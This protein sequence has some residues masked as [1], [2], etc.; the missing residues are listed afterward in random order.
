MKKRPL[1][2]AAGGAAGLLLLLCACFWFIAGTQSFMTGMGRLAAEKGSELLGTRVEVGEVCVDSPWTVTVRDVALYD[3]RDELLARAD[4]ATVRISLFGMIA[5]KPA[6][7]VEDVLVRRPEAWIV[8]RGDGS[9]NFRDLM[10]EESEPSG[11]R[12]VVR[13]EFGAAALAMDGKSLRVSDV[14]GS[15]DFADAEAMGVALKA[16]SD[17]A[18][19]SLSGKVG[20]ENASLEI[21]GA[22]IDLAPYLPWLPKDL[23]PESVTI[24]GG[25]VKSLAATVEKQ[26]EDLSCRGTAEFAKGEVRV[27]DTEIRDIEGTAEFTERNVK[28]AATA[29]AEGQRAEVRGS[30]G[31]SGE[32]PTL[33]LIARSESFDPGEV[34]KDIPY[35]GAVA[36][37][38]RVTGTPSSPAVDGE[39]FAKE[40]AVADYGFMN[41]RARAAYADGRIT[42]HSLTAEMF[43]GRVEG[44]GEFDAPT[45]A[46]DGR[47]KAEDV[48]ASNFE[49]LAE[50]LAGRVSAD[51]GF[52]GNANALEDVSV[53]GSVWGRDM[54]CYDIS[55]PEFSASFYHAPEKTVIDYLSVHL[56]ND[57]Q[58][59]L[60]GTILGKETL[61]LAFSGTHT[62]ISLLSRI[63][64]VF[65]MAGIA[66]LGGTV[67]GSIENPSVTA[68]F[69]ASD[70]QLFKQPYRTMRGAVSGSLD[71]VRIDSFSMEN[72]GKITWL[73]EGVVGLTG[74]RRVNLR[75]DTVG[76]RLEDFAALVA[77]DQP[78]TGD[79]DN[80]IT[81]TGTLDN[82]SVVGYI[83]SHRG[84][85][86][87]YLLSGMEGDYTLKDGVLTVHDF[88]IY[89]PL[90]DMDLNGT[91]TI[92]PRTLNMV[93]Q[94]HDI[95]LRRF[96]KKVPYPIEGHGVFDGKILGTLD[97]PVFD[98]KLTAPS[99]TLNG[100][101]I[102]DAAGEV[103]L[104]G[105]RLELN[106]FAF[107]QNGG[108]Y[109]LRMV[110][111]LNDERMTGKVKV[112]QG[113]I[114]AMLAV[115]NAKNDVVHGRLNAEIEIGGTM[116]VPRISVLGVLTEGDLRG[117]PL[118]DVSLDA[119][120]LGR[121][122]TLRRFEGRQGL[123][124]LAAAGVF[125]LDGELS[126]RV[127]AQ[128][129][130]AGLFSAVA[131]L[132][133][134]VVGT[135]DVEAELGG[136]VEF[137]IADMSLAVANGG[138][139]GSTFDSLTGLVHLRGSV[140][141]LEQIVAVKAEGAKTYRA[142][143]SGML[144]IKAFT[145]QQG[146]ELTEYD[147]INL[148]LALDDADLGLLPL[149]SDQVEWAMGETDG[150]V[151]IGG[152]LAAPTFDG[153]LRVKDGSV[154]LKALRIPV[155]ELNMGLRMEGDT[156]AVEDN[157]SGRMGKGTFKISGSMRLDGQAP[158]DYGLNIE[159]NKLEIASPYFTGPLT[160][161]VDLR[162]GEIYGRR[163]PKLTGRVAVDDVLISVPTLPDSE[164]ELP[165]MII[166]FGLEI[167]KNTHLYSAGLYDL[168]IKGSAHFGGT[169]RHPQQSGTI[170]VRRGR[171]QYLQTSFRIVEGE[172]YFNQVDSFLPS[173]TFK[174]VTRMNRTRIMLGIDGPVQQMKF[175][176]TSS[177]EMGQ[178]EILRMLTFRGA[179]TQGGNQNSADA[180]R[181]ALLL[182]GLQMSVLGEVQ[183]AIRDLLQLDEFTLST[184]TFEKGEKGADKS[185]IE[186]YNVQIGKYVTDKVMLRY[187]QSLTEDMRRYGVRYDFTDR[188][189]AFAMHDEKNRNWFG[190]EARI[191]F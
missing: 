30:V 185:T 88:H 62:D 101:T 32:E 156:I 28:L 191:S 57:G 73:A 35:H 144:P 95:D 33:S 46:F 190:F 104:R 21:E 117:Y 100:A 126:G 77:P 181:N 112:E 110:V 47:A 78:I 175:T 146:E 130:Q 128:N 99:L 19:V 143:A 176:L 131:G 55:A 137:P 80:V 151:V 50:G 167:G 53:Y 29:E 177:P 153:I 171:V 94:V 180:Q 52:A 111:N 164:G 116:S 149:L 42:V 48:D 72:G 154:K 84:S 159:A 25:L 107:R 34:M 189:S 173:A 69:F 182:A 37:T 92:G 59:G 79:I 26:G 140:V 31:L 44:Q 17:A 184:G 147:R 108:I 5:K 186:A 4:S 113:D 109:S 102:T 56:E 20:E 66:D 141:E 135:L 96:E 123:G 13:S 38:A 170:S 41:A 14:N 87:G 43:G 97:E 118:T 122:V 15:V 7:A 124:M 70:G 86:R 49:E 103:H 121:V 64:P 160:A 54:A 142:S 187:T 138:V 24:R 172:A 119:G 39:F 67:R 178:Q 58:V 106:P 127:S 68:E 166:D 91:L 40:G 161:S 115:A 162:E 82:P 60:E 136:T 61:D 63:D 165:R 98:G 129:I 188:F 71:G 174:A 93:V 148:R 22:D 18:A 83:S 114:A 2:L 179:S 139:R 10:E 74:E 81:V 134:D 125:D 6:E 11:F 183:N 105:S 23:L 89:S 163:M 45:M 36:F 120:L 169:T 16:R 65:D 157:A 12:G 85:Y 27:L 158:V 145:A 155:T 8:K 1:A 150:N 168:W 75:I 133:T 76:A 90:V 132:D 9:W 51:L 152:S 3:K